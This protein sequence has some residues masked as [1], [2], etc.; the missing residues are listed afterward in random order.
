MNNAPLPASAR[1]LTPWKGFVSVF[2]AVF[3][4]VF[5]TGALI[6]YLLPESYAAEARVRV[7]TAEQI[8]VFESPDLLSSVAEQLNLHRSLGEQYGQDEPLSRERLAQ[9]MRRSVQVR[10]IRNTEIV[11][12]RAYDLKPEQAARLANA[13]AEAGIKEAAGTGLASSGVAI[14]EQA[15]PP[16]K[17]VRPN[18]PLNLAVAALVGTVLGIMAG[19]V[20]AR[21]AVGIDREDLA[22]RYAPPPSQGSQT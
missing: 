11:S 21:L 10:P 16:K 19:G 5:L 6:T 3:L 4:V 2:A 8:S 18:K 14:V 1:K 17:P 7:R 9:I 15:V 20:G 13:I 12:I 22:R